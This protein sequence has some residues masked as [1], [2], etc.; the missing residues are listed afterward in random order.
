MIYN[1]EL[2]ERYENFFNIMK[3]FDFNK[4]LAGVMMF[5]IM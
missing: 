1:R 3:L 2:E 4:F 5:Q